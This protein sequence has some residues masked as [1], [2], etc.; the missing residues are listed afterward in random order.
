MQHLG[1]RV[2]RSHVVQRVLRVFSQRDTS[3]C[4]PVSATEG[5]KWEN[6]D[7]RLQK[8]WGN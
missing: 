8:D 5:K 3:V 2:P 7:R 4:P 6:V 1:L